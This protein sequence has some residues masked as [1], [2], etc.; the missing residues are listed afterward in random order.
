MM[1]QILQMLQGYKGIKDRWDENRF[2]RVQ[3][4]GDVSGSWSSWF[5]RTGFLRS[6]DADLTSGFFDPDVKMIL[7]VRPETFYFL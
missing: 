3:A 6:T 2:Q 7:E 4:H 1:S 5:C